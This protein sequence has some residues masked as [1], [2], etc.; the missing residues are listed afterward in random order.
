M[1]TYLSFYCIIIFLLHY[2]SAETL[3]SITHPTRYRMKTFQCVPNDDC[4]FECNN[5]ATTEGTYVHSSCTTE[6]NSAFHHG[7]CECSKIYCSAGGYNCN[8]ACNR[9]SSCYYNHIYCGNNSICNVHCDDLYSC[10]YASIHCGDN[11]ECN[12][13][14]HGE[15]SC[16][17]SAFYCGTNSNCTIDCNGDTSTSNV[18][19]ECQIMVVR[20]E[21]SNSL[22]IDVYNNYKSATEMRVYAPNT[23]S[24]SPTVIRCG[25]NT[26]DQTSSQLPCSEMKIYAV[27]GW[28]DVELQLGMTAFDVFGDYTSKEHQ[29][30]CGVNNEFFCL[31]W[32]TNGNLMQCDSDITICNTYTLK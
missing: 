18:N 27:E 19:Y 21:D 2:L 26:F 11:S 8:I 15:R 7:S 13:Y 32:T 16:E 10:Q 25:I 23:P 3:F 22:K 17:N 14:C 20:A 5:V 1:A 24:T 4:R 31:G 29:M 9:R 12:L 30:Y 28:N 6:V